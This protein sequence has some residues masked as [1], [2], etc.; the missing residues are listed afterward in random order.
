MQKNCSSNLSLFVGLLLML[1]FSYLS[2][3][4]MKTKMKMKKKIKEEKENNRGESVWK[5]LWI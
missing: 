2:T 5:L 1:R 3:I 4:L